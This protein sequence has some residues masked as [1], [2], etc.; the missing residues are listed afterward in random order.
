MA[1][2]SKMPWRFCVHFDNFGTGAALSSLVLRVTRPDVMFYDI[3]GLAE[4]EAS[5]VEIDLRDDVLDQARAEV[6][7]QVAKQIREDVEFAL[8]IETLDETGK[9]L[10]QWHISACR[11]SECR[12][13]ELAAMNQD[14]LVIRLTISCGRV[15]TTANGQMVELF[16]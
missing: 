16:G 3:M 1:I 15:E 12:W 6:V 4:S 14:G 11:I 7:T 13:S 10:E 5:T 9:V 8:V 2:Q